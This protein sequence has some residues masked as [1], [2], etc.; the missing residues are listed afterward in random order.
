MKMGPAGNQFCCGK[1]VGCT[2]TLGLNPGDAGAC[3]FLN[4]R[5]KLDNLPG[6]RERMEARRTA[7]QAVAQP[8]DG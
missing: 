3:S 1:P 7:Q 8:G 2:N 5:W 4:H 6:H